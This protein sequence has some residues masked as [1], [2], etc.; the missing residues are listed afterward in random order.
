[1]RGVPPSLGG[2]GGV[3]PED[4]AV[5]LVRA[6]DACIHEGFLSLSHAHPLSYGESISGE[7]VAVHDGGRPS[8]ARSAAALDGRDRAEDVATADRHEPVP[9]TF[10]SF[11]RSLVHEIPSM[12][13]PRHYKAVC[14]IRDHSFTKQTSTMS[15]RL[16]TDFDSRQ[17]VPRTRCRRTCSSRRARATRPLPRRRLGTAPRARPGGDVNA[18]ETPLSTSKYISFVIPHTKDTMRRPSGS[19]ARGRRAPAGRPARSRRPSA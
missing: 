7:H 9:Q 2:L 5:G 17:G 11:I 1:M 8:A 15:W 4:D 10:T 16:E 19:A 18:N 14:F 6:G 12:P 13:F 3:R